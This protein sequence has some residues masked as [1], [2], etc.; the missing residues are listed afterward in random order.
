MPQGSQGY[1]AVMEVLAFKSQLHA[2]PWHIVSMDSLQFHGTFL[3]VLPADFVSPSS[4]LF[5]NTAETYASRLSPVVPNPKSTVGFPRGF[6][7]RTWACTSASHVHS[8]PN[9]RQLDNVEAVTGHF[10]TASTFERYLCYSKTRFQLQ[11]AFFCWIQGTAGWWM[12]PKQKSPSTPSV[13]RGQLLLLCLAGLTAG[14]KI[15]IYP[16]QLWRSDNS[17]LYFIHNKL[18][19]YIFLYNLLRSRREAERAEPVTPSLPFAYFCLGFKNLK[20]GKHSSEGFF[21][22]GSDRVKFDRETSVS[23]CA[24]LKISSFSS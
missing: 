4:P 14:P 12:L 15:G 6:H 18:W 5:V 7:G 22:P 23:V 17:G 9:A 13:L 2:Q 24:K 8:H 16:V 20:Q 11:S 10:A 21:F 1:K 19:E 3:L